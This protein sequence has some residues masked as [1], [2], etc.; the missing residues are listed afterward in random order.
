M[1]LTKTFS[2]VL[3]DLEKF[4]HVEKAGKKKKRYTVNWPLGI[5]EAKDGERKEEAAEYR[6]HIGDSCMV[7]VNMNSVCSLRAKSS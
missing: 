6:L 4:S 3:W 7:V 1:V 2:L 5:C